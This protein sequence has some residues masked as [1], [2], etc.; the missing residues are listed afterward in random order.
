[1]RDKGSDD[2]PHLEYG[3][4]D[5]LAAFLRTYVFAG[6]EALDWRA[7]ARIYA[8]NNA[9]HAKAVL[10]DLNQLL[11]DPRAND[12]EVRLWL[13]ARTASDDGLL[14]PDVPVRHSLLELRD[15]LYER[16]HANGEGSSPPVDHAASR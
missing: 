8:E 4:F 15:M 6:G 2:A 14:E 16:L 12:D 7:V 1:M 11:G 3:D 10:A 9:K 5:N 13:R